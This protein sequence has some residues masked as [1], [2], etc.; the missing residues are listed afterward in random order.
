MLSLQMAETLGEAP[1]RLCALFALRY[2]RKGERKEK[3]SENENG[4]GPPD[5][6]GLQFASWLGWRR[7]R[8]KPEIGRAQIFLQGLP[9]PF[10]CSASHPALPLT[11]R[12]LFSFHQPGSPCSRTACEARIRSRSRG[13]PDRSHA[14]WCYSIS[15]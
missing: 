2:E 4:N 3:L 15:S 1:S 13:G 6:L 7:S 12:S 10:S 11:S 9:L 14:G 8:G 5:D